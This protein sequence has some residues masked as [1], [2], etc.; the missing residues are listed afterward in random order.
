[1]KNKVIMSLSFLAGIILLNSCLKDDMGEYWKD[2]LAGKMYAT[3]AFPGIQTK[4][5]LPIPDEV[6]ISFLV[7]ISGR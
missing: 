5:L 4:S 1:M 7:N 2:D 6:T 3:I